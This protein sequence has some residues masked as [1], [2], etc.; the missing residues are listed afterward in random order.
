MVWKLV[1]IFNN[2]RLFYRVNCLSE[3][4]N[5][6]GSHI[7][8]KFLTKYGLDTYCPTSILHWPNQLAPDKKYFNVWINILRRI[9]GV[10]KNGKIKKALGPWIT[11]TIHH[12]PTNVNFLIHKGNQSLVVRDKSTN[13]WSVH[14]LDHNIRSTYFYT[15]TASIEMPVI[16]ETEYDQ[17]DAVIEDNYY[18]VNKRNIKSI[19]YIQKYQRA[20]NMEETL[21]EFITAKRHWHSQLTSNTSIFN[22]AA[23][24]SSPDNI[25]IS[26]D[27][28]AKDGRGSIGVVLSI[29]DEIVAENY[30]RTPEIYNDIHSYRSEGIGILIGLSIYKEI[31]QYSTLHKSDGVSKTIEVE[32][33][34]K[35]MI[36]KVN[37]FRGRKLSQRDHND[38][39]MDVV[40]EIL[41]TLQYLKW[42]KCNN[43]FEI[44]KRAP[45]LQQ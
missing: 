36:D 26:T 22:E 11:D 16:D 40:Y 43:N 27:G 9:T 13:L 19:H 33:D 21:E 1:R 24:L 23:L 12:V 20:T 3:M 2:F 15:K 34:S 30:S 44:R 45:G 37:R 29:N 25:K 5:S 18:R 31:L 7:E 10:D 42:F 4:T 39:D 6:L 14:I 38:K 17:T 28:G 35:S 41:K 32:S 8:S